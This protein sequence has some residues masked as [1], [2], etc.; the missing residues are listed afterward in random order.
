MEAKKEN[1]AEVFEE[2]PIV[3]LRDVVVFPHMVIPFVVGRRASVRAL[4]EA[5]AGPKRIFLATQSDAKLDNPTPDEIF[6]VGVVANILQSLRLPNG[7][8]KVLVEG[9]ERA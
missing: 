4:E 9:V 3:P 5:L 7:N 2:L 8:I 6:S 1:K